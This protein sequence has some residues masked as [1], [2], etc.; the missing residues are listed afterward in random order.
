MM[1]SQGIVRAIEDQAI[2]CARQV[3]LE[4]QAVIEPINEKKATV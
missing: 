1:D 4:A 3:A 2:V